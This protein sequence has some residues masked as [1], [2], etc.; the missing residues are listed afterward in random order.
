MRIRSWPLLVLTFACAPVAAGS[1][2][3]RQAAE[4]REAFFEGRIRPVLAA[5]CY[6]CHGPSK[7]NSGLRVDRRDALIRGGDSGPAIAPGHPEQSLLIRALRQVDD[8]K[9]PPPPG[10]R[11][12]DAIIADFEH[13]IRDGAA[14][15]K[16]M[17]SAPGKSQAGTPTASQKHW[18]FQPVVKINAP[19]DPSGWSDD[20]VDRFIAQGLH[21]HGLKPV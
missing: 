8:L 1:A 16:Q 6:R 2:V 13:W 5:N 20:P 12:P 21:S 9:M 3:D 15:P 11:L 17:A 7:I 14:W 4:D 18:A 19:D 10:K